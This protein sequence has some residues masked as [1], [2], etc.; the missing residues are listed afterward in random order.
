MPEP[1]RWRRRHDACSSA[2]QLRRY[3]IACY[4]H[5]SCACLCGGVGGGGVAVWLSFVWLC[6]RVPVCLCV[7][8]R[9]R[10][11]L[12]ESVRVAMVVVPVLVVVQGLTSLSLC[13][14]TFPVCYPDGEAAPCR[15]ETR[16]I[17]GP[18]GG[19]NGPR[20]GAAGPTN[21]RV[22]SKAG[23]SKAPLTIGERERGLRMCVLSV[24]LVMPQ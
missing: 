7:I 19:R 14:C 15:G 3:G 16:G 4:C 2:L 6:G 5:Y 10:V 13:V 21:R 17:R 22:C 1:R 24:G 9:V 18:R 20:A 8:G 23:T 11:W 12:C